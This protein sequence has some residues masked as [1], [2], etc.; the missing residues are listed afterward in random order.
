[1]VIYSL[2]TAFYVP[3]YK[4]IFTWCMYHVTFVWINLRNPERIDSIFII[5]LKQLILTTIFIVHLRFTHKNQLNDCQQ[6]KLSDFDAESLAKLL[7]ASPLAF[8]KLE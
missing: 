5:C 6:K 4:S 2:F 7:E 1:M 8:L 3:I